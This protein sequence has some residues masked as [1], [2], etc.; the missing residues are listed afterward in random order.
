MRLFANPHTGYI[1]WVNDMDTA[2]QTA[3]YYALHF[4]TAAIG[5]TNKL[6]DGRNVLFLETDKRDMSERAIMK[7]LA[8]RGIPFFMLIKTKKGYH[9]ITRIYAPPTKIHGLCEEISEWLGWD[10][11]YCEL[12]KIRKDMDFSQILRITGKYKEKDVV[13]V[14][15][16]DPINEWEK[17]VFDLYMEHAQFRTTVTRLT[18]GC[19]AYEPAASDEALE[20]GRE[21][22]KEVL[23]RLRFLGYEVEVPLT[24]RTMNIT[25][26]GRA[27]AVGQ[28]EVIEV[29]P[30]IEKEVKYGLI[31]AVLYARELG[32][33]LAVVVDYNLRVLA[34][35]D[36]RKE[37]PLSMSL[38]VDKDCE[39][40]MLRGICGKVVE[41]G[42]ATA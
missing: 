13:V 10:K 41:I 25:V 37:D 9:L 22:H 32:K 19:P 29:K 30:P 40:C 39:G 20:K 8:H 7:H 26:E 11:G 38:R 23:E 4:E 18:R 17:K 2:L 15:W 28:D 16:T 1:I 35:A 12:A 27:D 5:I 42:E 36:A 34:V 33:T 24:T 21:A 6:P 31:Q 3:H 14:R